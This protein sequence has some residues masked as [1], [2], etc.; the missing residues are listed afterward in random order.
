MGQILLAYGLPKETAVVIMMLDKNKKIK[1]R[2]PDGDTDFFDIVAGVLQED[3]LAPYLFIICLDY[4]LRTFR[5]SMKENG[6]TL[7]KAR[8]R[9][10]SVQTIMDADYDDDIEILANTPAQAGSLLHSMEKAAGSRRHRH[11]CQCRKNRLHM[12]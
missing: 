4:V 11:P 5:D 2:S 6:I 7:I 1:V 8:S 10:Y 12:L 3:T 9:W